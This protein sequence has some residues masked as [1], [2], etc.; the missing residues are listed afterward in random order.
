MSM[1]VTIRGRLPAI[2]AACLL[3]VALPATVGMAKEKVKSGGDS[4]AALEMDYSVSIPI[5]DATG[6]NLDSAVITEILSGNVI[7]NAEALANLDATSIAVPEITLSVSSQSDDKA[8]DA[9]VTVTDL[10]LE[11]V[12]DGKAASISLTGISLV[13]DDANF[14]FGAMSAANLDIAGILGLYGLVE[15]A[16][17]T[18]LETIYTD[19]VSEGGTLEAEDVSCSFGGVTGAEFKARPLE[20]SL[21]EMMAIGQAMEDQGDDVDPATMGQF[22]KM[23]ADILTAFETSEVSFEGFDCSGLD[24]DGRPMTFSVAGMTMGGMSPGIYPSIDID[25]FDIDVEGDGSFALDNLTIKPMDL[26]STIATL[27]AAPAEVDEAWLE[28]NARAL[29]PAME[30]LSLSGLDI[31]IPDPDTE[32]AR[33]QAKVGA[34]DVSLAKYVNG[35]PTDLDVSATN[36]QAAIPE[37][38][39]E[40]ALE[41]MLALGITEVDAGF[42]IAAAW[43]AGS[44][45][46]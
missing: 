29:I 2:A 27:K 6:S 41:Q 3:S 18:S 12:V 14:V 20:T 17:Q 8:H 33:I 43:D 45:L 28:E 37:G 40:D 30:G 5:V 32:G 38:T 21:V 24:E 23:Y 36:I 31:D 10:L 7:E 11:N 13:A 44:T 4:A 46:R 19:L 9:T 39:G 22:L 34:F 35:I 25:G 1:N 16:E 26:A 42:R 15:T